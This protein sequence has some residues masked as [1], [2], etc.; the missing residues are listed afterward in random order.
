MNNREYVASL[1][2]DKATQESC[3]KVMEKYGDNHWWEPGVNARTLAYYQLKE[4]IW[5]LAGSRTGEFGNALEALM[6]RPV[7]PYEIVGESGKS[8]MAE[9]E[10]AW[11]WGVGCTSERERGERLVN[12]LR[13]LEKEYPNVTVIDLR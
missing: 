1:G 8:L 5:L 2:I 13:L 6:G 9:D 3:L 4:P 7:S 10:R 11:R 12:N